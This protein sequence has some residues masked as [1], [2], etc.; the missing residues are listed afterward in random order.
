MK[1]RLK[2]L[3]FAAVVLLLG[4]FIAL[5]N[6]AS[7]AA[8]AD[9]STPL[10]AP[11][12]M[13]GVSGGVNYTRVQYD[14]R[15]SD[16]YV[17]WTERDESAK[18]EV[19][20]L[21]DSTDI[22][23]YDLKTNKPIV[24]AA[25]TKPETEPAISGSIVVW[26]QGSCATCAMDIMGKNLDTGAT[27]VI[28]VSLDP[29]YPIDHAH[30]AVGGRNVAWMQDDAIMMKN[31]D[32]GIATKI[33]SLSPH[34]GKEFSNLKMSSNYLVWSEVNVVGGVIQGIQLRAYSLQNQKIFDV[35]GLSPDE[36]SYAIS[37]HHIIWN[38][39]EG[40]NM[41]DL[42]T[43]K[44]EKIYN[45]SMTTPFIEGTMV[46]WSELNTHTGR[47]DI[48]GLNL[49][50]RKPIPLVIDEA[51]K[52]NAVVAQDKLAWV[53]DG[54]QRS[55][56]I[57]YASLNQA[58][59]QT[60]TQQISLD[61]Q[62]GGAEQSVNDNPTSTPTPGH[63]TG[64]YTN[65]GYSWCK[66]IFLPDSGP[67]TDAPQG[68]IG[69]G[70]DNAVVSFLRTSDNGPS[71]GTIEI[72]QDVLGF[73]TQGP[74]GWDKVWKVGERYEEAGA[75]VLVRTNEH[76]PASV[77]L[78]KDDFLAASNSPSGV[79]AD[80]KALLQQDMANQVNENH[81]I[82]NIVVDNEPSGEWVQDC[83]AGCSWCGGPIYYWN[84]IDDDR[85]YFAIKDY[86]TQVRDILKA[87]AEF[88]TGG[89]FA[90]V[91][92][93]TPAMN[94]DHP[95]D[96][97]TY[98]LVAGM[99]TDYNR[100]SYNVYPNLHDSDSVDSEG[101]IQNK[102]FLEKFS[103][104]QRPLLELGSIK[105]QITELGWQPQR[106]KI[107][108][109]QHDTWQATATP[110]RDPNVCNTSDHMNHTFASDVDYFIKNQRHGA[111]SINVWIARGWNPYADGIK[112]DSTPA[113]WP[114]FSTYQQSLP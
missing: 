21:R 18:P 113:A 8:Y 85:M 2:T 47:M 22:M 70:T 73:T 88:R 46:I 59:T 75:K 83:N 45:Y 48:W 96:E 112:Q 58:L 14:A 30:P 34:S 63:C 81:W 10:A 90:D 114:W 44:V 68:W 101:H 35:G 53:N 11:R 19:N 102:T 55:G 41:T 79:V 40:S 54:G 9:T 107:C 26:Q 93:W 65:S 16:R 69:W 3:I 57:A 25:S 78:P 66:G 39:L 38:G 100:V 24:V 13:S 87:D 95:T 50:D 98:D 76:G 86:Y 105:S 49:K 109:S 110:P 84:G 97:I 64:P 108:Y 28:A 17:V 6:A 106:I 94:P 71:F 37:D 60:V 77:L 12:Q 82:K 89:H 99:V 36:A 4:L 111:E 33:V 7:P 92:F 15:A 67:D 29:S 56:L 80:I 23:G 20:D 32:G 31:L 74:D 5:N 27:F 52:S 51:N 42:E 104:T 103:A 62:N 61:V 72:V 43:G 1:M 91:M